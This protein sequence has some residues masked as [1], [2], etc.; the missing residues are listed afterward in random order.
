LLWYYELVR[1]TL[2]LD[3]DVAAA[4]GRRRRERGTRLRDEV[5]ELLR[6]GLLAMRER[7]AGAPDRPYTLPTFDPG[8]M[9]IADLRSLREILDDE[10]D[11][12]ARR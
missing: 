12:R 4:I 3:D 6:T 10:D 9:L 8:K 7:D 5:N 11:E 2:T 1:T